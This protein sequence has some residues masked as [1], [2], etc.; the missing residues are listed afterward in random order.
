MVAHEYA[1]N[2][3]A[4]ARGLRIPQSQLNDL[5][6]GTRGLGLIGIERIADHAGTTLDEVVG[7]VPPGRRAA[8]ALRS[9]PQWNL[10]VEG[11][12]TQHPEIETRYFDIAGSMN[13]GSNLPDRIDVP[14]V[15]GLAREMRGL[16]ERSPAGGKVERQPDASAPAAKPPRR[17]P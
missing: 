6:N 10:V 17:S 3:S 16:A 15:A 2:V 11:A 1:G 9:H 4:A 12:R 8:P 13:F 7:R 5:L 14:F